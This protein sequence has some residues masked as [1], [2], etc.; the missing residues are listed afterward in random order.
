MSV[1]EFSNILWSILFSLA[2]AQIL[3]GLAGLIQAGRRVRWSPL[4]AVWLTSIFICVVANWISVW[5]LRDLPTWTT[6]YIVL[7]LV[8]MFLQY[9]ACFLALPN[10]SNDGS[11]DLE[12]F[13]NEQRGRYLGAFALL[14][15]ISI[16]LNVVTS[17]L[18]GVSAWGWQ[19][20]AQAPAA[21]LTFAAIFFRQ[22]WLDW[23][24]AL[25]VLGLSGFYL[26]GLQDTIG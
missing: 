7:L 19:N 20:I 24:L 18:F 11:I 13:H 5:G 12:A 16:P 15:G 10:V 25:I 1:F 21:V 14:N 8:A 4:H 3:A 2:F 23:T 26:L 22:R 9:L 17:E 6:G